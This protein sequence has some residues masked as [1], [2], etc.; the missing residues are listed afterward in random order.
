MRL[1][2]GSLWR[3]P[4]TSKSNGGYSLIKGNLSVK[5]DEEAHNCLAFMVITSSFPYMSIVTLTFALQIQYSSSSR[6]G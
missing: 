1:Q 6:H 5:F 2:K 4:L 3:W